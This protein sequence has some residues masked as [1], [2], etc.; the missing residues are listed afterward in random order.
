MCGDQFEEFICGYWGLTF[1]VNDKPLLFVEFL[2]K[3]VKVDYV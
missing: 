2:C 3:P 1:E